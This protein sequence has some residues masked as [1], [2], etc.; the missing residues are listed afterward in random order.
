MTDSLVHRGPDDADVWMDPEAGIGLG[1]RR[2]SILD[3]SPLGRQPMHSACGR[4]AI[5][6]NG[7]VYNF[8]ELRRELEPLG[9][10]FRGG[11][12][13]EVL[14]AAIAQWGLK[15]AVSRFVGMFA[16]ALWDRKDRS[17]SLVRDRLGIKPLYYGWAENAFV[18]GSELKALRAFPDFEH[19]IDRD[20]LALF[21]RHN[22]VP[23]PRTIY[24]QARKLEAGCILTVDADLKKP[25]LERYWS[26]LEVWEAGVR[27]PFA[28]SREEAVDCLETLLKDAV[29]SRML[30]DV[31]LGA[32]LSGGIDS[33]TVVALMQSQSMAPVKTFSIGFNERRYNEAEHA[34]AVAGHLG[35]EHTELYLTPE[36]LMAV[37]PE[38]P[39][40]WDEPFAD[41]SQIPTYCVSRLAREHVTVSLSGDGGDELFTGYLR[42]FALGHWDK[43]NRIPLWLRR[44]IARFIKAL[45]ARSF[46]VFGALGSKIHSRL[47]MLSI[48]TFQNFYRYFLSHHKNPAQFV[49]GAAEPMTALTDPD[50]D[51]F[52]DLH[53]QM[54]FW[55]TVT[56]L[57][58]D[59]L[60][61]VDRASMAVSLEARVPLLDHR[62]VEFAA[63][64]PQSMK[65]QGGT[66]KMLLRQVLYKYVP[67]SLIERPKMGF[68][69]PIDSW[70]KNELREWA[71]DLLSEE[72]LRAQGYLNVKSVRRMWS[73][74]QSGRTNWYY[75]LW[76][77]LMFQA[78]LREW[79]V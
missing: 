79:K 11:S 65:I 66:G 64:I 19:S 35:T 54:T 1:H 38:I 36:D 53:H 43:L 71:E 29:R 33:S 4:Y 21:F 23:A 48:S 32:F 42:Y 26:A 51:R 22:Y 59:I 30:A 52:D 41:S 13:T 50:N 60:T 67:E 44:Q 39:R 8:K 16:F 73:E 78:W 56:Y 31:P 58:D 40:F 55:D 3:L 12:D 49:L 2:L 46:D 25:V 24:T 14:L 76:D 57:P 62:V 77:V 74:Y 18:F 7:E 6:Y 61:K 28:G 69:V 47:D 75:Y 17:L 37:V 68:A 27:S 15:A 63:G 9:H 34:K 45:P 20:A 5:A 10:S 70:L 72:V